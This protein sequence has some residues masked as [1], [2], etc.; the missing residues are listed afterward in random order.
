MGKLPIVTYKH[1]SVDNIHF[2]S[3]ARYPKTLTFNQLS[4]A[5]VLSCEEWLLKD[6]AEPVKRPTLK[7]GS[8]ERHP[9]KDNELA[10]IPHYERLYRRLVSETLKANA[11]SSSPLT[12]LPS[13]ASCCIFQAEPKPGRHH[14]NRASAS[15][16]PP[17]TRPELC[18]VPGMTAGG[19]AIETG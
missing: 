10:L 3:F 8:V 17:C 6:V 2:G 15:S 9:V 7:A 19:S 4:D 5:P 12:I 1:G 13:P 11:R 16:G 14:A 18:N